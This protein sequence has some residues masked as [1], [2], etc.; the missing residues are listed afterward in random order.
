MVSNL[1]ERMN[2][3]TSPALYIE[4]KINRFKKRAGGASKVKIVYNK[5]DKGI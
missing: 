2:K 4:A 3:T 5:F 1:I